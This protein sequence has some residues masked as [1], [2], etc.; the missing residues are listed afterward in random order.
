MSRFPRGCRTFKGTL[1]TEVARFVFSLPLAFSA[2][3]LASAA[4]HAG[5]LDASAFQV[6]NPA[7]A[8]SITPGPFALFTV[9]V[10]DIHPAQLNVGAG[11][12][13]KKIAGWDVLTPS[14]LQSTLLT[15]I[16]PV[17]IGP[18]GT[19][20][21]ENGHHTFDSL[22]QSLF[23]ASDPNV[24]IDVVANFSNL[25]N[26]QFFAQMQA[27]GLL[28]P[29]N[30]G[31]AQTID[32]ATGAPLPTSL[33]DLANDPYRTLEFS[34]LK[35]KNSKIFTTTANITGAKGSKIPGLDKLTG[36]FSDFLWADAY[37]NANGGLGLPF[38]SPGDIALATQWNLNPNSVTTMPNIGTVKVGQ[39]PGFILNQ[40][41]VENGTISNATLANGTLA[42][43]GT[44]TGIT[45]FNLGTPSN[46]ALVGTPQVGFVMQLGGDN[47][48]SVTLS[49]NNTYTGGTTIVAGTLVI[50]NDQAL[51]AAAPAS[52]TINPNNILASVQAANGIIF[53]SL[54]EGM[55]TLQIGTSAGNGTGTFSTNRPIAVDGET[56]TINLNGFQTTLNGQIVS[57]GTNGS[58]LGNES[59][60]SDL[61]I[62]DTSSSANGVLILPG[63]ANNSGFFGNFVIDSGT[64]RV[65]SDASLGNTTGPAF[66]IGQID[67]NG[68]TLQAGASFDSVRS[69]F[70]DS[71]STIDTNGF[72]MNFAGSLTDI[73]RTLT[74]TNSNTTQAGAVSFGS[75]DIGATVDLSLTGGPA[76]ESVTFT[77]G[78]D[79]TG[80]ATLILSPSS[81]TSLGTTE[82]VFST[83]AP[84]L[85]AGIA[86]AWI[87]S[88]NG[89]GAGSNPYNFV[90][91]GSNGFVN[92][93]YAAN[94]VSGATGNEAVEETGN[95]TLTANAAVG[96]LKVDSGET[97]TAAGQTLTVGDG[98]GAGG[99]ILSNSTIAGGTIAFGGSEAVIF[100]KGSSNSI[101]STITGNNGL[102]LA[103][104]GSLTIG[105]AAINGAI[106][107]DSGTLNLTTANT[108]ANDGV[109]L[110]DVKK[111]PAP[112]ILN[113]STN[114]TFST[115]NSTGN[116]SSVTFSGGASL[117]IGDTNNLDSTLSSAITE[118]GAAVTGALTKAGSGLLD[119]SG[120]S[121]GTL[122][123]V[124]GSTVAIDAGQLRV[125]ANIFKNNNAV[126]IAQGAEFQF[127][128]GGGASFGGNISGQGDVRLIGGTLVLTGIANTYSGGTFVEQGSTLDLTTANVSSGNAN[129]TLDGGMVVFDQSTNGTYSGVISDG[130]QMSQGGPTL[131]GTLVKDDSATGSGGN[132]TLANV[133]TY[134]GMTDV[135]AG[136]LTLGAT[137]AIASSAG[138]ILGRVGGAVCNPSPCSGVNASLALATDNTITSVADNAGNDTSV[139]LNGHQLTLAPVAGTSASFAGAILDGSTAGGSLVQ[140]G[141]GTSILTGTSTYTGATIVDAGLLEVD[142]TIQNTS[143]VTVNSGGTL[144][145]SGLIDPP[146]TTTI[147]AGGTFAPGTPGSPGTSM[148]I[149][150]NLAF[151]SGSTYL[152]Q[153]NSTASTFANITGTVALNGDVLA[154]VATDASPQHQY[155]I[156]QSTGLNGTTFAGVATSLPGFDA[157]L[158]DTDDD[159]L[160]NLN[161]ALGQGQGLARNQR[162]VANSLNRVFNDGG[163]LPAAFMPVF[164]LSGGALSSGLAQ[165]SGEPATGAQESAF[166]M[167]N[168]F[169]SL[170]LDPFA[171]GRAGGSD[172][173][174]ATASPSGSGMLAYADGQTLPVLKGPPP[175]PI[176]A[177]HW[178]AWGASFGG[179]AFTSGNANL[180]AA[181]TSTTAVGFAV[182]ADY[183][184]APGSLIGVSLAGGG[185]DWSLGGGLGSGRS[186]VFQAGLYGVQDFGRAYLA[187]AF[188]FGNY[189]VT[190]NRLV[191]IPG[192]GTLGANYSAQG[193]GGRLEAGYH[194]PLSAITFTPY[195]ALQPQAFSSP[196][197]SEFASAG[198]STFALSYNGNTGTEVRGEL[199]SWANTTLILESHAVNLFGR[200][201]YAHDWQSDPSLSANFLTLPAASFVVAGTKPAS[202]LALTTVG[203]TLDLSHGWSL[204][205]KFDG[206]FGRGSQSYAGT[207]RLTYNW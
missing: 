197:F 162:N 7:D 203:A 45:S 22:E 128:E 140:D 188:A 186:D 159:V 151:Q 28:L 52:Y 43:D 42:A 90:T 60:E 92:A 130:T 14:Q 119:L 135:E 46:P 49:G 187:G 195:A 113:F 100:A 40:D 67:L 63:S 204:T 129:I 15:D 71:G 205:G 76:G 97:I 117:T 31:V 115:L 91:Y 16:E 41:L 155:T 134:T 53:N 32:P 194:V 133:Q 44:F 48:D 183:H 145:G 9:P 189:W 4:A 26:A 13:G 27:E 24:F 39:L 110:E 54:D 23:G 176:F 144:A 89:A 34:I 141:P 125:D 33:E 21:L 142:G 104:S 2:Y 148:T 165:I 143:G 166:R 59:G 126:S 138:V 11:E 152:V 80:N 47:S 149:D 98:T 163:T 158:T 62:E 94:A 55:G 199:G 73:Q 147:N 103:G 65:S 38:L 6:F 193:Y 131:A 75:F 88:D 181:N 122:N 156:L 179:G 172:G 20:F 61:T 107:I 164:D 185:T 74:I 36:D 37:R 86:P 57:L 35:N 56:A 182:G 77:N 96:A 8:S 105:A 154:L 66:E 178:D 200:L 175:A 82:K 123:L 17:V 160:L 70:L 85:V 120:M 68:G 12:V 118:T 127:V 5:Q 201:A 102:T 173:F 51:G 180:G 29:L 161:A 10:D 190:T 116:N 81:A 72:T 136:T 109:T 111:T 112:A 1:F 78:I 157:T 191:S 101:T 196:A 30:N 83:A 150:G 168:S 93:T 84:T 124:S 18:G 69:L 95:Q 132:L 153:L 202:D 198:S 25:T 108:F 64:L 174:A 184:L 177:P 146:T 139:V 99:I 121:S 170:L 167:Q 79:R 207:G 19:L 137:N 206:E 3:S 106:T 169:L 87:I 114:Q 171:E 50:A 58:G 192:G